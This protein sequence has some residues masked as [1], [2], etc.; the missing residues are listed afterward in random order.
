VSVAVTAGIP[1]LSDMGFHWIE[2]V[3]VVGIALALIATYLTARA[4]QRLDE[5]I[6][7]RRE[8]R[9]AQAQ[10]AAA[11]IDALG[12]RPCVPTPM[13]RPSELED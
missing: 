6:R 2:I 10:A 11:N 9:R 3:M 4:N 5:R 1:G 8:Q 13:S 7:R 12:G